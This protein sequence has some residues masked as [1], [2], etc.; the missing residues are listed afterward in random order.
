MPRDSKSKLVAGRLLMLKRAPAVL[1]QCVERVVF[2]AS[3]KAERSEDKAR[4]E[5]FCMTLK[6][7]QAVR[8][9]SWEQ[10]C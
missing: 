4:S 2:M 5:L 7:A 9:P 3:K 6:K 1:R 8:R 10:S